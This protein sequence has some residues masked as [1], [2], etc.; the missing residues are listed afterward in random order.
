MRSHPYVL[1]NL[2]ADSSSFSLISISLRLAIFAASSSAS[3]PNSCAREGTE[4]HAN[5][6][7]DALT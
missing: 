1:G 3:D 4:R 7:A 5:L 6:Q 2:Q